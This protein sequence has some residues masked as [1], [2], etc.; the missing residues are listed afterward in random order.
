MKQLIKKIIKKIPIAFTQNQQYDK[1]T[2]LVIKKVCQENSNCVDVG[3]HKGEVLDIMRKYAPKGNH[4][5]FEPIPELCQALQSKYPKSEAQIF[6]IAL[7]NEKGIKTFNFVVSN[8]AYS[9]LIKRQYD[10]PHEQDTPIEV[11]VD[12]L[13][14]IIPKDTPIAL[15]KIDVEGGEMGV[16]EGGQQTILRAK[17]IIIFEHGMGASDYYG[18]KPEQ[19]YDFLQSCGYKVV[20]MKRW[21]KGETSFSKEEFKRQFY[22]KLNYYFIAYP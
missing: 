5:G 11:H 20:T 1:Q 4:F 12:L 17:P 14:H 19:L 10:K 18:T 16:L 15:M 13:D 8:P 3:C 7:S 22:D 21:L 6:D 9:G 2:T